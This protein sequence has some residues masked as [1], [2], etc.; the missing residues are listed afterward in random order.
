MLPAGTVN[1]PWKRNPSGVFVPGFPQSPSGRDVLAV[2]DLMQAIF[3]AAASKPIVLISSAG[4]AAKQQTTAGRCNRNY[5]I[6]SNRLDW[7]QATAAAEP[8]LLSSVAAIGGREAFQATGGTRYFTNA[9]DLPAPGTQVFYRKSV[10][11][12]ESWPPGGRCWFGASANRF[13]AYTRSTPDSLILANSA[14]TSAVDQPLNRWGVLTFCMRNSAAAYPNGDFIQFGATLNRATGISAGNTNPVSLGKFAINTGG[15]GLVGSEAFEVAWTQALTDAESQAVDDLLNTYFGGGLLIYSSAGNIRSAGVGWLGSS[16]T[17]GDVVYGYDGAR[18]TFWNNYGNPAGL[19]YPT[20]TSGLNTNG[21]FPQPQ[22]TG[23]SGLGIDID[24]GGPNPGAGLAA[25][26]AY[27]N[28]A[29]ASPSS[30]AGN[31]RWI[32]LELG[33]ADVLGGTYVVGTSAAN[34]LAIAQQLATVNP[35]ATIAINTIAPQL[36]DPPATTT[37]STEIRGVGG[38]WDQFDALFPARP[39]DRPDLNFAVSGGTG[40]YNAANYIDAV[41]LNLVGQGLWGTEINAKSAASMNL[42]TTY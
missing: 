35:R 38:V 29:G 14:N 33:G 4:F 2:Q 13:G 7:V 3:L 15:Q 26:N 42:A 37:F 32:N 24:T 9:L 23:I 10:C 36:G 34:L 20:W 1:T 39:C 18:F 12:L 40:L 19:N 30:G 17:R 41:H 22:H 21:T 16:Q 28:P 27:F 5:N 6:S 11:V 25:A 31:Y 8:A